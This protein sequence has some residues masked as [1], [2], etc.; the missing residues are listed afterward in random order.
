MSHA[1]QHLHADRQAARPQSACSTTRYLGEAWHAERLRQLSRR[2]SARWAADA[3]ERWHR[4]VRKGLQNYADAFQASWINRSD[5]AALLTMVAASPTTPA[6]RPSQ[7]ARRTPIRCHALFDHLANAVEVLPAWPSYSAAQIHRG[8]NIAL[9]VHFGCHSESRFVCRSQW[10]TQQ[11]RRQRA[12]C[13][14]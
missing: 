13:S 14:K 12:T 4:P 9:V 11:G 1:C 2:Q 7:R 10:L 5:A 6:I 8:G 3:I